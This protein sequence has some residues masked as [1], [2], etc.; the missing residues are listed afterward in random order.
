M[1]TL[2]HVAKLVGLTLALAAL[3]SLVGGWVLTFLEPYD[4]TVLPKDDRTIDLTG[5]RW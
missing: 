2:E 5:R 4:K 1:E 3:V